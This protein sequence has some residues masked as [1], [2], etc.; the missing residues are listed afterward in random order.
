MDKIPDSGELERQEERD[1]WLRGIGVPTRTLTYVVLLVVLEVL[2]YTWFE[3][4]EPCR[5]SAR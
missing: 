4:P 1:R 3:P 5:P 2:A